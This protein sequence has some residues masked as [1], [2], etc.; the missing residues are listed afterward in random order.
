MNI[1]ITGATG[2]LGRLV[3]QSLIKLNS[4][5][6]IIALVRDLDKA[7]ALSNQGIETRY[8]DYDQPQSLI[9]ALTGVDKLLL[10]SATEIGRRT[11]QHKA[12]IE[13][14]YAAQVP[15]IAYTSLL[16]ANSTA[17][18][19]AKEHHETEQL[20]QNSGLKYTF[21]RNNWYTENYL[22]SLSNT[23]ESGVL[24]AAA[25]DGKISSATRQEYAEAA[26]NVLLNI[27]HENQIYELAGSTAFTLT[28]LAEA[29]SQVSGQAIRYQNLDAQQ[30]Q[31]GLIQAG[32]PQALV[33]VIVDADIHANQ[34]A[35][36]SES[37]DLENLINRKTISIHD[38][39]KN[40]L[41][42]V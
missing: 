32:L 6:R 34:G 27:G 13:A 12:V 28:D 21:L 40:A 5:H 25:R 14:A 26:A 24:Y 19:V 9:P 11:S 31:Q 41:S 39:V 3:I 35:L 22:A 16:H 15:Y 23:I 10:I 36:Y 2:L 17:L 42:S 1:A 37:Q 33:E 38:A 29:I 18:S 4:Q 20:I 30:Y 7:L 8:F